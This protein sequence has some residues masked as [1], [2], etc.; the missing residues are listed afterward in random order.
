MNAGNTVTITGE[1][2][3]QLAD[4]KPG[5]KIT[6]TIGEA[7]EY[8]EQSFTADVTEITKEAVEAEPVEE[9]VPAPV[10]KKTPPAVSKMMKA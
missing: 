2:A 5:E 10:A 6:L 1:L 4:C 8:G 3:D 9:E 7:P